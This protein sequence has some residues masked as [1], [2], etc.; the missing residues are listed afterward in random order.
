MQ[1]LFKI[2][3]CYLCVTCNNSRGYGTLTFEIFCLFIIAQVCS[4]QFIFWG[5]FKHLQVTDHHCTGIFSLIVYVGMLVT[6]CD[7]NNVSS[8]CNGPLQHCIILHI[9]YCTF[10]LTSWL[11]L[12]WCSRCSSLLS[13]SWLFMLILM[14]KISAH[15]CMRVTL[16]KV[17]KGLVSTA[18]QL[19]GQHYFLLIILLT[20][21]F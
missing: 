1:P 6:F 2:L 16:G 15:I 9:W 20:Q 4:T 5:I 17:K 8:V 13:A 21:L 7:S 10:P 14:S 11:H 18:V 12:W 19:T 3:S